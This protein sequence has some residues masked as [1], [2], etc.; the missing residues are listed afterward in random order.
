MTQDQLLLELADARRDIPRTRNA[1]LQIAGRMGFDREY[2]WGIVS[3]VHEACA[4]A[5]THGAKGSLRPAKVTLLNRSDRFEA[6]ISDFGE[7][8]W[9]QLGYATMP[10][11]MA[12]R[13][14]GIPLMKAMMDEIR[15]IC[16]GGCTVKMVK[17][18]R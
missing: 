9:G 5:V 8:C 14:R 13:G 11:P 17:Y 15:F 6:I 7:G 2:L 16:D 12:A 10:P 1:V 3:A 18:K 4:N